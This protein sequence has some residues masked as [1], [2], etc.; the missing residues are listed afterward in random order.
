MRVMSGIMPQL[1]LIEDTEHSFSLVLFRGMISR[2]IV[3]KFGG[4]SV[5]GAAAIRQVVD[6]VRS[7]LERCPVIV[8]SAHAGVTDALLGVA[9]AATRG[10]ADT[11]AIISRHR[12]ILAGLELEE[13]LLDPLL[14]ELRDLARGVRLVGEA[15]P[16]VIDAVE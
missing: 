15:T 10:E 2:V 11:E 3:M 1:A 4:T 7:Q 6:V 8:V 16:K 9:R 12:E 5:G 13:Q 14:D